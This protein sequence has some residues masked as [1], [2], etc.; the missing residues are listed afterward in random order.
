MK[1]WQKKRAADRK[2]Q[3]IYWE[4]HKYCEVCLFEG[5]GKVEAVQVHEIVFRSHQ[6]KCVPDN[7][8]ST[9]LADH[10]RMHFRRAEWLYR[11]D[12]YKMKGGR[13]EKRDSLYP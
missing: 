11:E 1:N 3:R 8:I 4:E 12:L 10:E 2:A 9:C 7:M 5:R 13:D 6:G